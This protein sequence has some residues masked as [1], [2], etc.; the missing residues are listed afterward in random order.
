MRVVEAAGLPILP[1]LVRTK[2]A[3]A[4][5]SDREQLEHYVGGNPLRRYG[6]PAR[7]FIE[8]RLHLVTTLFLLFVRFLPVVAISEVKGVM[9]P[10]VARSAPTRAAAAAIQEA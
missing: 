9:D 6:E 4:L 1:G 2:F 10:K 7:G 5:F 8:R 3:Q